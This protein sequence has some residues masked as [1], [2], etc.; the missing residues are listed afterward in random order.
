MCDRARASVNAL[1]ILGNSQRG[2]GTNTL[3]NVYNASVLS[4]LTYVSPVW[5][6]GHCQK[7]LIQPIISVQNATL[8]HIAGVFR[9][10]NV[11]ALEALL[12]IPPIYS[13]LMSLNYSYTSRLNSL[14]PNHPILQH[15]PKEWKRNQTE[16]SHLTHPASP[17][18]KIAVLGD[19]KGPS[20]FKQLLPP[21]DPPLS[22]CPAISVEYG[23]RWF[24][25][26]KTTSAAEKKR[27]IKLELELTEI[28]VTNA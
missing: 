12:S 20:E 22:S 5:F 28:D 8:R 24:E 23:K 11:A 25:K 10:T 16:F 9:T 13:K 3:R 26:H 4:V 2:T 15:L 21:W 27:Y 18:V 14:S 19:P 1:S 6:T 17:L 7:T